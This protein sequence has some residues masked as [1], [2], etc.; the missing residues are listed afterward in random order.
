MND[1]ELLRYS[2]HILLNEMRSALSRDPV[3][4]VCGETVTA[5][6][7]RAVQPISARSTSGSCHDQLD[8]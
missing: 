2:R 1:Q 6:S 4:R 7:G 3:C 8:W 5:N